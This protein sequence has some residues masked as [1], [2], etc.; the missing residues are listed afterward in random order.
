M[1]ILNVLL[2]DDEPIVLRGV[3]NIIQ[4]ITDINVKIMCA[5]GCEEALSICG[6][7]QPDIVITDISMPGM[8]GLTF[9]EKFSGEIG[10]K[11]FAIL[12]C[13][14]KFEYA[15]KAVSLHIY[16]FLVKPINKEQLRELLLKV[17]SEV[18]HEYEEQRLS[19]ITQLNEVMFFGLHIDEL[20]IDRS[21][22]IELFRHKN[23]TLFGL[24]LSKKAATNEINQ[25]KSFFNGYADMQDI[26][27]YTY[28][29][30][31]FFLVNTPF[32]LTEQWKEDIGKNILELA[33]LIGT[34]I[35]GA[36][37]NKSHLNLD[38]LGT[39]CTELMSILNAQAQDES[40]TNTGK[41]KIG[42]DNIYNETEA[43]DPDN[44]L[45][46]N[47]DIKSNYIRKIRIYV[48][49]N[50]TQDISL[51]SL[52]SYTNLHPSYVSSLFKRIT[53]TS[54]MMYVHIVRI[55]KA[56]KLMM[57]NHSLSQDE[58]SKMVGYTRL[59]NY[60][61]VFKK[62]SGTTPGAFKMK[63]K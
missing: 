57:E 37:F 63:L 6:D 20:F 3:S 36:V 28:G 27:S 52:A 14:S 26:F 54:V 40:S 45:T 15:Q 22:I 9:V 13:Y 47:S 10:C 62:I 18:R 39:H 24:L 50:F 12:T 42:N 56:K 44:E 19:V 2:I 4:N 29:K 35:F 34:P 11:R 7:Y 33:S 41:I 43:E 17:N 51:Q 60:Y 31:L 5:S 38:N 53:G 48:E 8:D 58:V 59:R 1:L 46:N 55:K 16:D 30:K 32:I 25:L 21:H 49:H 61:K 23:F